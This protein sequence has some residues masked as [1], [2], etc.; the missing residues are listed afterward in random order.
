MNSAIAA[1]AGTV[2]GA[3]RSEAVSF[4]VIAPTII[5]GVEDSAALVRFYDD[6]YTQEPAAAA[7]YARWRALG[8]LGKADHV[9]ELCRRA[10]IG[11]GGHGVGGD[12]S[13]TLEV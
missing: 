12:R 4:A 11:A 5:P 8:A 1:S 6:A 10:G 3:S 2:A 7:L 13:K 9:I